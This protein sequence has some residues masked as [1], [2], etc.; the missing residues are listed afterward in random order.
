MKN[1]HLWNNASILWL[2]CVLHHIIFRFVCDTRTSK[3]NMYYLYTR[4]KK[5]NESIIYLVSF[6]NFIPPETFSFAGAAFFSKYSA[7]KSPRAYV[8]N[9]V[10]NRENQRTTNR[11]VLSTQHLYIRCVIRYHLRWSQRGTSGDNAG[12]NTES[13]LMDT[14]YARTELGSWDVF[15]VAYVRYLTS[16]DRDVKRYALATW[17]VIQRV[18]PE[19]TMIDR[20]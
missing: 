7:I 18:S 15:Q 12:S 13:P 3:N 20:D 17:D 6:D 10:Y 9:T 14:T 8:F 19:A 4:H 11:T 16:F 2:A 5:F 1:I